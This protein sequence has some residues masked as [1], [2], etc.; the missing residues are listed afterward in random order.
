MAAGWSE[1]SAL[2]VSASICQGSSGPGLLSHPVC[3]MLIHF[4]DLQEEADANDRQLDESLSKLHH[5]KSA[6]AFSSF[7]VPRPCARGEDL[8]M[9]LESQV[10]GGMGPFPTGKACQIS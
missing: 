1:L 3:Q 8:A 5:S 6:S 7:V 9:Q 4:G 10:R 2:F